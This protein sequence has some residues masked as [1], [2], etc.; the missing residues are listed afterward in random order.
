MSSVIIR[1][2]PYSVYGVV[3]HRSQ[4]I[5]GL[6]AHL[7]SLGY[8]VDLIEINEYNR[9]TIEMCNREIFRCD[10][11]NLLFNVPFDDDQVCQRAIK[12]IEE[13]NNRMR[14]IQQI[15]T[16]NVDINAS[17]FIDVITTQEAQSDKDIYKE[18]PDNM[19]RSSSRCKLYQNQR[20]SKVKIVETKNEQFNFHNV[21]L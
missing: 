5:Y 14:N 16:Q 7:D 6:L 20:V 15:N 8:E 9:L 19:K 17:K 4:K 3:R 18:S 10:I 11:R 1:Y 21:N 2:G 13:A 12:V